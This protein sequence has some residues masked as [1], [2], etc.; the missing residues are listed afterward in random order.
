MKGKWKILVLAALLCASAAVPIGLAAAENGGE[1]TTAAAEG[2]AL[3]TAEKGAAVGG[4][5]EVP[6]Y[7][8]DSY[9]GT[10]EGV[11]LTYSKNNAKVRFNGI[12]DLEELKGEPFIEL[13]VTPENNLYKELNYLYLKLTDV[14]NENNYVTIRLMAGD[15]T[16]MVYSQYTYVAA[17]PNG[18]NE[19]LGEV[20]NAWG[21]GNTGAAMCTT[22]YGNR[23]VLTPQSLE[24]SYNTEEDAV[25]G[26]KSDYWKEPKFCVIDFDDSRL[27][28]IFSSFDRG[29]R[30]CRSRRLGA[31]SVGQRV[32]R[33][34]TTRRFG[35]NGHLPQQRR[36]RRV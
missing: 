5:E 18:L 7:M 34:R 23:G 29:G 2:A 28:G 33:Y 20:I 12:I 26:E 10:R 32:S 4:V 11:E 36:Q 9:V 13:Q 22:F 35:R 3:F 30:A 8:G 27:G 21:F 1:S 31:H 25:Y 24:L 6:D 16:G 15:A 17:A 19:P 14:Y